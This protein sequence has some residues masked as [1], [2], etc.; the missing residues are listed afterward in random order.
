MWNLCWGFHHSATVTNQSVTVPSQSHISD[1]NNHSVHCTTLTP[2][3]SPPCKR[4][5]EHTVLHQHTRL[6]LATPQPVHV[7][8]GNHLYRDTT[9]ETTSPLT[10]PHSATALATPKQPLIAIRRPRSQC[11]IRRNP[12]V[13]STI[14]T[15]PHKHHLG[16]TPLTNASRPDPFRS[17]QTCSDQIR[18]DRCQFRS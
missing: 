10:A 11:H 15:P 3:P 9:R 12:T 14:P 17:D 18:S 7:K 8:T 5:A 4:K 16:A 13:P 6:V 1:S 2:H